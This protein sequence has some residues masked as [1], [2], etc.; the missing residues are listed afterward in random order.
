MATKQIRVYVG[1]SA[2]KNY[3]QHQK[4]GYG[5]KLNSSWCISSVFFINN[6]NCKTLLAVVNSW[7][8]RAMHI[9]IYCRQ[10]MQPG[11]NGIPASP[12]LL[13]FFCISV[14][15]IASLV[16]DDST[17]CITTSRTSHLVKLSLTGMLP[18]SFMGTTELSH[19][20]TFRLKMAIRMSYTIRSRSMIMSYPMHVSHLSLLTWNRSVMIF[21]LEKYGM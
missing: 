7:A 1:F 4:I 16:E 2:L 17:V 13:L 12:F 15:I 21:L 11:D 5:K 18:G 9:Y 10:C 19:S 14:K 20:S 8:A 3:D 6:T